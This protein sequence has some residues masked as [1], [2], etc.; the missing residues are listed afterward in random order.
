ML[1]RRHALSSGL[2]SGAFASCR[3][4]CVLHI[5]VLHRSNPLRAV[6]LTEPLPAGAKFRVQPAE[7]SSV[8]VPRGCYD[9][10]WRVPEPETRPDSFAAMSM[11][12][13][14]RR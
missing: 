12:R 14:P 10:Q 4:V 13:K 3:V 5:S 8:L 7:L 1:E 6:N 9:G 11:K 2:A